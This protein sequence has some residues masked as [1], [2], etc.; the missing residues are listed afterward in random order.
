MLCEASAGRQ[1]SAFFIKLYNFFN[2]LEFIRVIELYYESA[3]HSLMIE[4]LL[5]YSSRKPDT[6]AFARNR[7]HILYGS[8]VQCFVTI[9]RDGKV[10]S[11]CFHGCLNTKIVLLSRIFM[12]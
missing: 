5:Q 12:N 3:M 2:R 4:K 11:Q 7:L 1:K 6:Q 9:S 8:A 10:K